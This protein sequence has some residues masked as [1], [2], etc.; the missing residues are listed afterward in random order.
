MFNIKGFKRGK[1]FTLMLRVLLQL[2][3]SRMPSRV[4]SSRV[5]VNLRQLPALYVSF[6]KTTVNFHVICP[7]IL[8][9][10][11]SRKQRTYYMLIQEAANALATCFKWKSD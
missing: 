9:G 8:L 2:H 4:S 11:L 7:V 1:L 3:E 6:D 5:T 10:C